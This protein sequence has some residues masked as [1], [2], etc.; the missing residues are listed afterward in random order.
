MKRIINGV[1]KF[2]RRAAKTA[3]KGIRNATR[4]LKMRG[5]AKKGAFRRMT[6]AVRSVG[7]GFRNSVRRVLSKKTK[8][9][10]RKRKSL[11]RGSA[12][13]PLP[14]PLP[15]PHFNVAPNAAVPMASSPALLDYT[16][17]K[18]MPVIE[19]LSKPAP[20]PNGMTLPPP[21]DPSELHID[22]E[23]VPPPRD[24]VMPVLDPTL[25]PAASAPAMPPPPPPINIES[26]VTPSNAPPAAPVQL[27][28]PP[29]A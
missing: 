10:R 27:N 5:G 24:F 4:R 29:P 17:V 11:Q 6:N 7:K 28:L 25:G 19:G 8:K 3:K 9:A 20:G 23:K 13:A 1:S 22:P 18:P 14:P 15:V 12:E 16:N 26:L 21:P 2:V